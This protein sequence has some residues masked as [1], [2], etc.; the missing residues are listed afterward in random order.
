MRKILFIVYLIIL[1]CSNKNEVQVYELNE[2]IFAVNKNR[3]FQFHKGFHQKKLFLETSKNK[4]CG[5]SLNL[6]CMDNNRNSYQLCFEIIQSS[7]GK[8][9]LLSADTC[10]SKYFDLKGNELTL[11]RN[12]DMK[13]SWDSIVITYDDFPNKRTKIS[14]LDGDKSK[15]KLI[16]PFTL[17]QEVYFIVKKDFTLIN[18][19]S[20]NENTMLV[21]IFDEG[22]LIKKTKG[23]LFPNLLHNINTLIE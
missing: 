9:Q 16:H 6:H 7:K 14:N 21:S 15:P 1:S 23:N 19:V 2:V 3:M 11:L 10:A 18:S 17:S 22:N 13:I 20:T 5:S 4:Y 12:K 8:F